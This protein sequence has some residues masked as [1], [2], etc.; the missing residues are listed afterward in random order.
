MRESAPAR[1][2][3][4][5][6]RRFTQ[7]EFAKETGLRLGTVAKRFANGDRGD[8]LARPVKKGVRNGL[9]LRTKARPCEIN[10]LLAGWKSVDGVLGLKMP[11]GRSAN[12]QTEAA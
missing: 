12:T 5:K 6:G 4:W 11:T 7:R 3:E 8:N 1:C 10:S 2:I 9:S